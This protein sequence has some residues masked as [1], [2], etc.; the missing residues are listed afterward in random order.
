[1]AVPPAF[2]TPV[3]VPSVPTDAMPGLLLLHVP[4]AVGSVSDVVCVAHTIVVPAIPDGNGFT[5]TV[6][7]M[8]QLVGSVYVIVVVPAFIPVAIPVPDIIVAAVI[9][10]LPHVPPVDGSVKV[11]VVPTHNVLVP[12]IATGD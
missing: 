2:A 4:P 10:L 8:R 11:A 7:V 3:T 12:T 9:L 1:M 6:A 5:V